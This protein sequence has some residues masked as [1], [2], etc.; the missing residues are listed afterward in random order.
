MMAEVESQTKRQNL[1]TER[2][3]AEIT[4]TQAK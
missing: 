4:V 3:N 1:E 2:I